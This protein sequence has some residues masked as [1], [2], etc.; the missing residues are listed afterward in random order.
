MVEFMDREDCDLVKL[1][2]TYRQFRVINRLLSNWRRIYVQRIRPCMKN[3][4]RP[5]TLLDIGFGGGD[6]PFSISRW[7]K[8]DGFNLE[9]TAIDTDQ[10]AYEFAR[11][12]PPDPKVSF[13]LQRS[14][15]LLEEGSCFDF[16]ISNHVLHHLNT[17]EFHGFLEEA[18]L[19]ANQLVIFGDIER[20]DLGYV[21]FSVFTRPL[22]FNSFISAD[23]LISIKRSYTHKELLKIAPADWK[24]ER[25]FPF[26]LLLT[27]QKHA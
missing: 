3:Q 2:N 26:R 12:F 16:V 20:S 4:S 9:I 24:V 21:L 5:Y 22:F 27:H 18:K 15:E 1:R 13:H 17:A 6:I 8:K 10:R 19:L 25:S 11:N 7:A 14:S 23:G